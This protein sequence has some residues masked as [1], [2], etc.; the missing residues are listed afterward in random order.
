MSNI[1]I[2]RLLSGE[3]LLGDVFLGEDGGV[4][5]KDVCQVATSYADPQQ[6]TAKIGIAPYL[7]YALMDNGI[8][9][10]S[11]YIGFIISP[12]VELLNEYNKIFGSGIIVPKSSQGSFSSKFLKA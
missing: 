12:V 7:P 11:H 3:E 9:I 5:I 2:V 1:K 10:Q 8:N 4:L 6:A